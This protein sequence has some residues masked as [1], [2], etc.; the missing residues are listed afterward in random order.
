MPFFAEERSSCDIFSSGRGPP[1]AAAHMWAAM[2]MLI[3]PSPS[4]VAPTVDVR[5]VGNEHSHPARFPICC[6][7]FSEKSSRFLFFTL[8]TLVLSAYQSD[9]VRRLHNLA[10]CC[11]TP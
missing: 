6:F 2:P 1:G 11:G 9:R 3:T 5:H 4:D 8:R 10:I 7:V